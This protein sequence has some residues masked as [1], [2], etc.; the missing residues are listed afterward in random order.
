ERK[1]LVTLKDLIDPMKPPPPFENQDICEVADRIID[2][3]KNGK[4]VLWMMGAHVIKSGLSPIIIDL[5]KKN[6]ITH[7]ASNGAAAIHDFEIALIGET[8]E[9][10]ATSIEDG[11]FGMAEETGLLMN[12]AVQSGVI[13]GFGFGQSLGKMI[14]EDER[15]KFRE[16]SVL[17]TAYKLGVPFT[18]HVALGTD[19]IH[20]HPKCNFSVLGEATGRDF[21]TYTNTVSQLEG[22]VFLNF[23]SAVIGPEVFLKALSISR[24]LGFKVEKFTTA[25]FDLKPINDYRQPKNKDDP[26]YYYRPL[27]NIV[28]RPP[29][30]GGKGFHITGDHAVT[31]P[32]LYHLIMERTNE[33]SSVVKPSLS[34]TKPISL[35]TQIEEL[36]QACPSIKRII[37]D[38]TKRRPELNSSIE[39]LLQAYKVINRCFENGGTLFICG[40]GG[41]FAD[42]FHISAELLKSFKQK[43]SI[44]EFK[45]KWFNNLPHSDLIARS[46]EEGLRVIVIGANHSLSSAVEND[47]PTRN[48]AFAQELYVLARHGDVLL[49]ISTSGNAENVL[50]AFV[51]AKALG[52]TTIVLTGDK[53]GKIAEI[54]D[55]VIRAPASETSFIQESHS[56]LYHALCDMLETSLCERLRK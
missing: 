4:H 25:N 12:Q 20:Q 9:D 16:Y 5:L 35:E 11:T 56:A 13:N 42:A 36:T 46:L 23:G 26:D 50:Y 48:M 28:I 19:I 2:A 41:S 33:I 49:G 14:S 29:S 18:V 21:K 10:V 38:L 39:S 51:T 3:R 1:N 47:N 15:F 31:I 55:A 32:N 53:G 17:Y 30:M 27:K 24:N 22:G 6:V 37:S 34:K 45:K 40:N 54:A 43:R 8:S 52:L 7:V 44:P